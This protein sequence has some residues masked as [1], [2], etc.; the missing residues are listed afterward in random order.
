MQ[1]VNLERFTDYIDYLQ[2]YPAEFNYLFNTIL[3]NVTDFFRDDSAWEYLGK[4]IIPNI[5]RCKKMVSRFTFGLLVVL[6]EKR[7]IL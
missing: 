4:Q 6:L 7:L 1:S 2:V 5:M 3:M